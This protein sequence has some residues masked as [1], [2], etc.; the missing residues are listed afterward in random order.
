MVL[1][2]ECRAH[3]RAFKQA[4]NSTLSFS[5]YCKNFDLSNC[6]PFKIV[7]R[8]IESLP[9]SLLLVASTKAAR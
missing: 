7:D 9:A 6:A 1:C 3:V 8:L 2:N 4:T 5:F